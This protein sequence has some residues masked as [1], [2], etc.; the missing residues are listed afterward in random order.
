MVSDKS[1]YI[2]QTGLEL[3]IFLFQPPEGW[4]CRHML[5]YPALEF[6][7]FWLISFNIMSTYFIHTATLAQ[8][9]FYGELTV[10]H[11]YI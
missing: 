8:D 11:P 9:I 2:Y 7:F 3:T 4:G 10:P 1:C 6:Y 5:P